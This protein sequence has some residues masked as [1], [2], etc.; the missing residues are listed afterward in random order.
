M[1]V[2]KIERVGTGDF[3]GSPGVTAVGS[4]QNTALRAADPADCRRYGMY[5]AHMD[6]RFD[7]DDF[8]LRPAF[9]CCEEN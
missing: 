6:L 3:V 9:C 8:P 7:I 1:N 2:T 5:C 4:F